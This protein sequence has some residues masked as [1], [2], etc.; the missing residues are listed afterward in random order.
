MSS[1][2]NQEGP[3]WLKWGGIGLAVVALFVAYSFLPVQEW[4]KAFKDW[5]EGF[6][7]LGWIM[8]A[9]IYA[10]CHPI[11][12]TRLFPDAR[13]RACLWPLGI[14]HRH[15]WG[16]G[17]CGDG[18]FGRTLPRAG[19]GTKG[20]GKTREVQS[21]RCRHRRRGLE[22]RRSI[23]AVARDPIQP[24]ELVVRCDVRCVLAVPDRDIHRD[25]ARHVA[26]HLDRF[27][28]RQRCEWWRVYS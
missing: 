22:S 27:A 13:C 23:K 21:H 20:H 2:T 16:Y 17:R 5:I 3:S 10:F 19:A 6:G 25:Y 4:S 7:A 28:R 8:F 11:P 12:Y 24:A 18:I 1:D 15:S 9:A 26:L 14:S